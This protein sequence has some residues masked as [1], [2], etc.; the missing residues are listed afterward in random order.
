MSEH[1]D[2]DEWVVDV[3]IGGVKLVLFVPLIVGFFSGMAT[4]SGLVGERPAEALIPL[5][6]VVGFYALVIWGKQRNMLKEPAA[7][8][9]AGTPISY[10]AGLLCAVVMIGP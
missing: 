4:W 1:D 7:V 5:A 10:V 9:V 2:D 3:T 6:I 8:W